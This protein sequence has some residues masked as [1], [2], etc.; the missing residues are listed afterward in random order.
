MGNSK[1]CGLNEY[2]ANLIRYKAQ[3]LIGKCGLTP[4]DYEDLMQEM[5]LD[6]LQ[7]LPKFDPTKAK[8][9]T[10]I[11]RIIDHKVST[12]IRHCTQEKRD[13]R[14]TCSLNEPIEDRDGACVTRGEMI[15][16]D[17]HDLHAGKHTRAESER[18]ETRAVISFSISELPPELRQLAETGSRLRR[19]SWLSTSLQVAQP[20]EP[21]E[22][23]R[24][25]LGFR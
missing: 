20:Q 21:Q 12:I 10:F 17:D 16:Q 2:A 3:Q 6:L 25:L 18:T 1:K 7:R 24:Y 23:N 14:R 9:N 5:T 4:D 13:Y 11:A 15:S 19:L 8:R 22:Q